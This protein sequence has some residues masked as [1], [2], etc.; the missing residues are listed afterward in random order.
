MKITFILPGVGSYLSGGFKVVYEYANRLVNDGFSVN[1]IYPMAV[2]WKQYSLTY[3]IKRVYHYSHALI[4]DSYKP[5]WFN[6][7]PRIKQI[8]VPFLS[9]YLI[10]KS[11]FIFATGW[12]TA[13]FLNKL[14]CSSR[15]K[16]YLIQSFEDWCGPREKVA[17]TWKYPMTKI[18]IAPWLKEIADR[19][20]EESMLI[21]NGFDFAAFPLLTPI[22]RRDR[23]S[24]IMLYHEWEFKGSKIGIKA[25]EIVKNKYPQLQPI[26]FGTPEKPA[27]VPEWITYHQTPSELFKLYNSASIYL[28]TSAREGFSLTVAE[29]MQCGCAVVCTDIGGYKVVAKHAETA[30]LSPIGDADNLAR[31]IIRLIEDDSLRIKIAHNGY[32]NIKKYTW[33]RAYSKLKNLI[34]V[35]SCMQ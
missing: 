28:G 3:K 27:D 14:P 32:D 33:E 7:E 15:K 4:K 2:T 9:S 16:F 17:E 8:W 22:E 5:T 10:P 23:Y 18:V 34:D 20:G 30:L 29:A 11:D 13:V 19:M 31:N 6:V 1:V 25:L 24:I 21:E 35:C 12:E 26:F